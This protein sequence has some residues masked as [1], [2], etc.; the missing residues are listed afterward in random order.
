MLLD[1]RNV[2]NHNKKCYIIDMLMHQT[3]TYIGKLTIKLY[4]M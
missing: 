3:G 2:I 1:Y 4:K